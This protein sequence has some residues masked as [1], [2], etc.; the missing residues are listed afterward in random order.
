MNEKSIDYARLNKI[1]DEINLGD[2]IH[3]VDQRDFSKTG[4]TKMNPVF[5]TT[6]QEKQQEDENDIQDRFKDLLM[7]I[8]SLPES[9]NEI[10]IPTEIKDEKKIEV[11][12]EIAEK[13]EPVVMNGSP[14][15]GRFGPSPFPPKIG[16]GSPGK[17]HGMHSLFSALTKHVEGKYKLP[18]LQ[19]PTLG[20]MTAPKMEAFEIDHDDDYSDN[21][22]DNY[23]M[24]NDEF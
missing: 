2:V 16:S 12:I 4:S 17:E 22:S 18:T 6:T 3:Q 7:D 5:P 23:D 8:D 15:K 19:K 11:K 13:K 21:N 14:N 1:D 9:E 24:L 10:E 20:K